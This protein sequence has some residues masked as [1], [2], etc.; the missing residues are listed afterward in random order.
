M[1]SFV[2]FPQPTDRESHPTTRHHSD[3]GDLLDVDDLD[4]NAPKLTYPGEMITSAHD[5]MR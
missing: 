5:T 4:T 1:L 2:S 3:V